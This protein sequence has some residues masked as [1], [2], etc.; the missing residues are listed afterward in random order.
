MKGWEY[1]VV[2]IR[3]EDSLTRGPHPAIYE[4]ARITSRNLDTSRLR[5]SEAEAWKAIAELGEQGWEIIGVEPSRSLVTF[6]TFPHMAHDSTILFKRRT[7][8]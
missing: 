1:M 8:S 5:C 3:I 7:E 2:R 6:D 4:Y